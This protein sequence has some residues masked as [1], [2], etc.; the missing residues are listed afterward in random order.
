MK[1]LEDKPTKCFTFLCFQK[2]DGRLVWQKFAKD[3]NTYAVTIAL[4]FIGSVTLLQQLYSMS[5]PKKAD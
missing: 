2:D 5:F 1:K 4:C 3:R